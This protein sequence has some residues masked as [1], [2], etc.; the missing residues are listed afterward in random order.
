MP[1][2]GG[3]PAVPAAGQLGA[4]GEAI[5]QQYPGQ[6]QV[7]LVAVIVD[8][9]GSWFAADSVGALGPSEKKDKYPAQ[10]VEFAPVYEFKKTRAKATK[11]P[12]IIPVVSC[13]PVMS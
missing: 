11:E 13:T 4:L 10:A 1:K 2:K 7:D 5:T 9:P 12:G 8:I 3:S 6:E